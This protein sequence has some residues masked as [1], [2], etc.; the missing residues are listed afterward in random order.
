VP[1]IDLAVLGQDPRYGGGAA[2]Q[3]ESFLA[4]AIDAGRR[5]QLLYVSHPSLVNEPVRSTLLDVPGVHVPL[6]HV[7]AAQQLLGGRRQAG[8]LQ[9]ARSVWVAATTASYGAAALR[10][11]QP[12]G[13]WLATTL[14]AEARVQR[15]ELPWSRRVAATIN[16]PFLRHIERDVLRG[17]AAVYATSASSRAEIAETSGLNEREIGVLPVP[18]N[19]SSFAPVSDDLWRDGIAAPTLL[20]VGRATDP[21]KNIGLL[22]R[23][24]ALI[25]KS[26][27][28]ARL[29]LVGTPPGDQLPEGATALGYVADLPAAFAGSTL[30][31]LPSLQEGFAIVVAE[32]LAAGIP[33]LTTP[34]GGPEEMLRVSHGGTILNGFSE[35]EFAATAV[36]M[37][38]DLEALTAARHRG[39]DFAERELSREQFA[40]RLSGA[41]D[42]VDTR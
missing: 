10:G 23:A 29:N 32:A 1:E 28:E 17:A 40:R 26:I 38:G 20:F 27:P 36:A 14:A 37:L 21:R 2:T 33:V 9:A 25:R 6:A 3:L 11:A 4:G 12:Y 42:E 16:S 24:F 13:C 34:C 39:R 5:P 41:L 30:F 35:E 22:L 15:P 8:R 19:T 18:V 7:A 31:V